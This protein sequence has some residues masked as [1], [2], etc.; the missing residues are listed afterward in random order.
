MAIKQP[1][2]HNLETMA[3]EAWNVASPKA[4]KN[5][6]PK[7]RVDLD[8]FAMNTLVKQQG[9]R[10]KVFRTVYCPNVKSVDGAE[11]NIDCTT[12]NGSGWLDVEPLCTVALIQSQ[13]LSKLIQ[14][15]GLIDGN[16]VSLTLPIG[17]EVTYFTL[18]ELLDF[19][20]I[21]IQRVMKHPT[22]D[23]DIL[24]YSA[25]RVNV[26]VGAD[27]TRYYQDIDFKLNGTGDIQ[28][29][30]G[31]SSPTASQPYSIHYEAAVQFRAVRAM[32]VNR[33]ARHTISANNVEH[34]KFPENWLFAKEFLVKRIAEDGSELKQGPYSTHTITP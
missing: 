20:D 25:C 4:V 24:K 3:I 23:V 21:F 28:W 13:K 15:E 18:V 9:T 7:G 32:H 17:I 5:P 11:H 30:S 33:F 1:F 29:I 12:C 34:L 31:A 6:A 27:G 14:I 16:I 10:V 26:L 2:G 8:P 19:T 22:A